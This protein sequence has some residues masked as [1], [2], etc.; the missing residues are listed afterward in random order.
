M[1]RFLAAGPG[2]RLL[3]VPVLQNPNCAQKANLIHPARCEIMNPELE[4]NE[5][6][7]SKTGEAAIPPS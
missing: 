4:R 6:E 2:S 7:T 5:C 3:Q 1:P